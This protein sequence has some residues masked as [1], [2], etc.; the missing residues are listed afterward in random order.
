[1]N[2]PTKKDQ[3]LTERRGGGLGER[4]PIAIFTNDTFEITSENRTIV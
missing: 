1:M 2:L 3:P 4:R